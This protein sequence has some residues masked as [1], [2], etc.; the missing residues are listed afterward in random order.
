MKHIKQLICIFLAGILMCSVLAAALPQQTPPTSQRAVPEFTL[1]PEKEQA[2]TM[3]VADQVQLNVIEEMN[4]VQPEQIPGSG[5]IS[6]QE[7]PDSAS[8]ESE[9]T[10]T[11]WHSDDETV[12]TVD[13][14]GLATAV[15]EG[16]TKVYRNVPQGVAWVQ[17]TV[18]G[19]AVTA[20]Q[21]NGVPTMEIGTTQT[22]AVTISPEQA[23]TSLSW[24][25][26]NP[27]VLT[28][29][30]TGTVTA[31][32][33]GKATITATADN[34]ISASITL[35]VSDAILESIVIEPAS[36]SLNIGE[37]QAVSVV[38][39][40]AGA[41][42]GKLSWKSTNA[43]IAYYKNGK[44]Y[45]VG[46]GNA[47]ITAT[48][49][50]GKSASCRV[51]VT[52]GSLSINPE[53]LTLFIGETQTI[54]AY[55]TP[56]NTPVS[57]SSSNP[58]V[59]RVDKNGSVTAIQT[60]TAAITAKAGSMTATCMI[61]VIE[62][63]TPNP[64]WPSTPE[65]PWFDNMPFFPLD[66][67]G[68]ILYLPGSLISPDTFYTMPD[69]IPS[70]LYLT[71]DSDL[72]TATDSILSA[73]SSCQTK[74][75]F[76][77]PIDDLYAA[78]DMLRHIAGS[79]N[80]IGFLLTAQQVADQNT[81]QLLNTANEQLSV[82]TGTPTH[83]VRIAGGSGGSITSE[84]ASVLTD[85]GYRLWDWN[86]SARETVLSAESAYESI[87]HAINTTNAMTIRFGSNEST[88]V[89]LQQ[90]LPYLTYC[91]MPTYGISEGDIPVC[92]T[93]VS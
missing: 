11:N 50:D 43:S 35:T 30:E 65:T 93:A 58:A 85:A 4:P 52:G 40:P 15:G 77:V 87:S 21:L 62:S 24:S 32:S 41:D 45:G 74:A 70:A 54:Q 92:D 83:L 36:L 27:E 38:P 72:G 19:Y 44:I 67:L 53:A 90:L 68:G 89:V 5:S 71:I 49:D 80:S 7:T 61:T 23:E 22:I 55:V 73:L 56:I 79:G 63:T 75:T 46:T 84:Q 13:Q 82:I 51:Q 20:L 76:F 1:E 60:G 6:P 48:T 33:M 12:V 34:G 18:S 39:S 78:D 81:I 28:V 17:I 66:D 2:Y 9:P 3:K 88:A 86:L 59:A 10:N 91:G 37:T 42:V 47:T 16:T 31:V 57:W 8:G 14:N 25:S 26:D 69:N 64:L 29:D